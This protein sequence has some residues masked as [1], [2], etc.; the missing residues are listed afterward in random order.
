MNLAKIKSGDV[1][2][3]YSKMCK[4]L[5]EPEKRGSPRERQIED[6]KRYL[7]YEKQGHKFLIV[8]I[9]T[10]PA[11]KVD[12]RSQGNHS[13]YAQPASCLL[14]DEIANLAPEASN[15]G[16]DFV[17]LTNKE[18]KLLVGLCN[19]EYLDEDKKMFN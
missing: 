19:Q 12:G 7:N 9:Y 8:E 18:I 11:P 17:E 14:L 3:N 10:A 15:E 5:E 13:V 4:Q 6:W 2:A 1:I 16:K